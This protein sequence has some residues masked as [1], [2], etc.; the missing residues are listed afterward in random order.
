LH[1]LSVCEIGQRASGIGHHLVVLLEQISDEI[2]SKG[3]IGFDRF[4]EIA[5]YDETAGYYSTGRL[6]SDQGGDFLTSAE[7]SPLFGETIARFAAAEHDRIGD[8]F[9]LVEVGGG[10]G[11]LLRPLLDELDFA[12][13]VMAVER[14]AAAR[15]SIAEAVPEV[16][17]LDELAAVRGVVVANELLDNMPAAL[18]VRRGSGWQERR[19]TV[20]DDALE[21]VDRPPRPEVVEWADRYSG[22]VPEGGQVEVQLA[23]TEWVGNVAGRLEAGALLLFD[24][25][26]RAENLEH[27]RSEGTVRTYR[28]HHLGPDP[29]A[30]PGETDI[31][32][33]VNFSAMTA[34]AESSGCEVE[35]LR[36]DDFLEQWGLRD[37]Q[38]D[39]RSQ[40]LQ[41]AR[42]GRSMDRLK[43]RSR[44]TEAETLLH[45]RGLGDFRVMA[46]RR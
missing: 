43:L 17:I 36:Q 26:D 40:E 20:V 6:R 37:R 46:V 23:A 8:P 4:M 21:L 31:T 30:E 28:A 3:P 12:P 42:Q 13:R 16:E 7:V 39:L 33:D 34:A 41:A 15:A 45:P 25:G 5:L 27:R 24:Y 22:P 35:L 2:R 32:M 11:S 38:R 9:T 10:S 19:V 44:F 1:R 18:V 14:S 29:L